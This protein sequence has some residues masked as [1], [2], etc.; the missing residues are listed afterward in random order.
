MEIAIQNYTFKSGITREIYDNELVHEYAFNNEDKM[1]GQ[2][3]KIDGK[4][5]LCVKGAYESILP[6]CNLEDDKYKEVMEN[7]E[8]YASLG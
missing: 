1:M 5:L 2:V 6:L 4:N 3:W 8:D 7:I